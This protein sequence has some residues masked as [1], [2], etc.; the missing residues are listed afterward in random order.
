M[1]PLGVTRWLKV[2]P[3]D[4]PQESMSGSKMQTSPTREDLMRDLP[5][6]MGCGLMHIQFFELYVSNCLLIFSRD[7]RYTLDDLMSGDITRRGPT[8]GVLISGMRRVLPLDP[9][10]EE[11]L[12][13]FI[14]NRNILVHRFFLLDIARQ[15]EIT[16]KEICEKLQFILDLIAEADAL[17]PIFSGL[18]SMI[19]KAQV[20][21]GHI[22]VDPDFPD[23]GNSIEVYEQQFVSVID[24]KRI[25]SCQK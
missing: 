21:G 7:E 24:V 23:K 13:T 14:E 15:Q 1:W 5:F 22:T 12:N 17:K 10:F 8:L 6:A 20:A 3:I 16:G 18:L 25:G 2:L 4:I 11:R 9:K 19:H